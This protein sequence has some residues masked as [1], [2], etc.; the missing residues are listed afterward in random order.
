MFNQTTG[1]TT[2]LT[3]FSSPTEVGRPYING[4]SV[5]FRTEYNGDSTTMSKVDLGTGDVES[6]FLGFAFFENNPSAGEDR[7]VIFEDGMI[8]LDGIAAEQ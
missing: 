4:E 2:R 8:F 7:D 1:L 6:S 5:Y 3:D